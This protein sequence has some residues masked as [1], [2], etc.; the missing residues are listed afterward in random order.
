MLQN[1]NLG[2]APND[3]TGTPAREAGNIINNN[4]A[5][6]EQSIQ[7]QLV[8]STMISGV[9]EA[10]AVPPTGNIHT[11]GTGPGTYPNW[12][13]MVIPAN[14]IGSL[15]RVDGVYSVSLTPIDISEKAD[16]TYVDGNLTKKANLVV[17]KNLFDK[18]S[19]LID[20]D[21]YYNG[22]GTKNSDINSK[23][24]HP[25]PIL[26]GQ[27]IYCNSAWDGSGVH[28]RVT[29][30]DGLNPVMVACDG[31]RK[32]TATVDGFVE[33]SIRMYYGL[34]LNNTQ[35]EIGSTGTAYEPYSLGIPANEII[36]VNESA[37]PSTIAR[38]S[39]V[40][41]EI[42]CKRFGTVGVDC[43]F[44]GLNAI[45]DALNSIT[46]ASAS[47]RYKIVFDGRFHFTNPG[48]VLMQEREGVF[49]SEYSVVV[50]K[51][52][53]DIEGVGKDK[54][55]ISVQFSTGTSFPG[56]HT[57][58][59]YQPVM[60][61]CNSKLSNC[62]LIA[63]NSRYA[64][65]TDWGE[66]KDIKFIM[67]NVKFVHLGND[68]MGEIY[69]HTI[70]T[71]IGDSNEWTFKNCEIVNKNASAFGV[72][73]GFG[74]VLNG[75][76]IK[77]EDCIFD[78]KYLRFD[79][80]PNNTFTYVN[81]V[82]PIYKQKTYIGYANYYSDK[83]ISPDY[84]EFKISTNGNALPFQTSSFNGVGKL[85][86]QGL[87]VVD[88]NGIGYSYVRFDNACTAFNSIIG[89][90]SDAFEFKKDDGSISAYGYSY[91]DGGAGFGGYAVGGIDIDDQTTHTS[92]GKKLGNCLV[93]NKTLTIII[94]DVTRNLIFNTNLTSVSNADILAIINGVIGDIGTADC[95]SPIK[96]YFPDF[97]NTISRKSDSSVIEK[98][99]AVVF[100]GV[101]TMRIATNS[102]NRIDGI[103]LDTVVF[104]NHARVITKGALSSYYLK[105]YCTA[106]IL[107][108]SGTTVPQG[109]EFGISA[110]N[111][112]KFDRT[113]SPKFARAY[114]ENMVEII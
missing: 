113:A 88:L 15:Q 54:S 75:G 65:H 44:T 71:G 40:P 73:S 47:K 84:S 56:G 34:D 4:F 83:S 24:T 45:K 72:H 41:T 90:S 104:G 39:V 61:H 5:Y 12:G 8:D 69:S 50:G 52:W 96:E 85:K 109:T 80:Y 62:Q 48:D 19:P 33:F 25:I 87:R 9:T 6:L 99:M 51:D 82:N 31:T 1:L 20:Q 18:T 100:I 101:D 38:L 60:W 78:C 23:I 21:H 114:S 94:R 102:D 11:I 108:V 103:C 105:D 92:L 49:S 110:A 26:A 67:E 98:G 76:K 68:E 111:A 97:G 70:G 28:N 57:Y 37:I 66:N 14:N 35:A 3:K 29:D 16:I 74:N 112:G 53:V 79:T 42:K 86:G 32:V 64:L 55:I 95:Y 81:F 10:S 58:Q 7:A 46:D 43:D 91:K 77:F 89:N 22:G 106:Y 30:I 2:A 13:G 93:V 59:D 36:M 107:D 17:G 63:K 27:T